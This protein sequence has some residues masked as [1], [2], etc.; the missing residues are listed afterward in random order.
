MRLLF[1]L[2]YLKRKQLVHLLVLQ[3]IIQ[4]K[5][6]KIIL[7]FKIAIVHHTLIMFMMKNMVLEIIE[8]EEE[9]LLVKLQVE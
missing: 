2:E 7:I 4:I 5:N 3:F 9:V 6:L 8:V 1:F